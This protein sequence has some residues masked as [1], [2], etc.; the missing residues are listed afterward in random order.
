VAKRIQAIAAYRPKIDLGETVMEEELS[1]YIARGTALNA[2]EIQ[3]VLRELHEALVF[4]ARRGSPVRIQ[5]LG[6]F[7]PTIQTDGRF[8]LRLRLD[9][10]L[11][12]DLNVEGAASC[13][14]LNESNIGSSV[15]EMVARWDAE[16]PDDPIED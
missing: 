16:H 9:R 1:A 10:S 8:R 14:V 4:F 7:R 15:G 6:I 2:G 13:T 5:G 12:R 11:D 3:N